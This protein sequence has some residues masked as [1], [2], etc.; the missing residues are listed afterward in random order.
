MVRQDSSFC[1]W[2]GNLSAR[3]IREPSAILPMATLFQPKA[4]FLHQTSAP[5]LGRRA[6]GD[7]VGKLGGGPALDGAG[8]AGAFGVQGDEPDL[9]QSS[10]DPGDG[11]RDLDRRL[12]GFTG[13]G[14]SGMPPEAMRQAARRV[15]RR[16]L[17]RGDA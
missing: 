3:F 17:G 9:I 8:G 16:G 5:P 1:L 10:A 6:V 13:G 14:C 2:K 12:A 4:T 15:H 7:G 11:D